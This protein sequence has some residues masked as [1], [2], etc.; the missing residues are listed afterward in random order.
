MDHKCLKVT[1]VLLLV[2]CLAFLLCSAELNN[3]QCNFKV[4]STDPRH[5]LVRAGNDYSCKS[6]NPDKD[7]LEG[8]IAECCADTGRCLS[9]SWNAPWTLNGSHYMDC[10][11]GK[12]CC[13]LKSA[14]PPLEKNSWDMN[15]T[16]GTIDQPLCVADGVCC[17]L[18]GELRKRQDKSTYCVCD[19][20]WRGDDCGEL[21]L[22]PVPNLDGAYQTKVN[23]ADCDV[24]C[25][26]SSWGGLP[27]LGED[28][29]YHLFASQFVKNCT[30]AGW[31][32][33]STVIRAIADN[34]MGPFSFEEVVFSTF[35]HNPTVRLLPEAAR[36][37]DAKYIMAMIG[38]DVPPPAGTGAHCTDGAPL[39]V[40]HLEGYIKLAWAPSIHGPWTSSR[41]NMIPPGSVNDWDAMVTN[42]APL[43]LDNGTAYLFY[44]GTQWPSNGYE[45]IGVT[46]A[47][48]WRGP[49]GRPFNSN[50]PLWDINDTSA[51]VEDPSVWQDDRGFHMVGF[52]SCFECM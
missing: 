31:N 40:H 34:P 36:T 9:F 30:L 10:I 50:A 15:I 25:G 28:G 32:P 51:F 26:P 12:N 44:R 52:H 11:P 16:T 41:H 8:C 1:L 2:H 27:L 35:H 3:P 46:M 18:N 48:T 45:R 17:S 37:E 6:L 49:Y 5:G 23:M 33:G 7:T 21:D 47:T 19:S 43:I 42:P 39:D 20:G 24:S 22:L 29:K 4:D 13:C 38:D 14:V